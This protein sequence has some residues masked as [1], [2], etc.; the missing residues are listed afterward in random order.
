[1]GV[2]VPTVLDDEEPEE[3]DADVD[4]DAGVGMFKFEGDAVSKPGIVVDVVEPDD[5]DGMAEDDDEGDGV[6][7]GMTGADWCPLTAALVNGGTG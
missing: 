4:V 2:R 5:D 6:T 3:P 7:P 1:M